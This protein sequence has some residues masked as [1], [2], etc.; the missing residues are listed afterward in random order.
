MNL[1]IASLICWL[2][3]L[4]VVPLQA[5]VIAEWTFNAGTT[6]A[7][8]LASSNVSSG[9]SVTG[10]AFN[11]SFTDFGP[12]AVPNDVHDGFGFGGATEGGAS[13]QVIFLHRANYFDGSSVPSPRPTS[14]DYTSWG[15][16]S[17]AGT[18]ADPSSNGNAPISFT[19]TADALS[20]ITV[21]SL[22]VDFFDQAAMIFFFQEA[23]ATAGSPVTVNTALTSIDV[24]LDDP[25]VI[26]P[27]QTRSFTINLN[28][29][30]LDSRHNLDGLALNGKVQTVIVDDSFAKGNGS[31]EFDAAGAELAADNAT[32]GKWTTGTGVGTFPIDQLLSRNNTPVSDGSHALAI[33]ANGGNT[34]IQGGL[35]N[36]GY[37]VQ[38]DDRFTLSFD[39]GTFAGWVAGD[40][41][42]VH[43]FTTSDD[44]LSGSKTVIYSG[45]VTGDPGANYISESFVSIGTVAPASEGRQLWLEFNTDDVGQFARVDQVM[46]QTA[47]APPFFTDWSDGT[48]IVMP[49]SGEFEVL[50]DW[51]AWDGLPERR[52]LGPDHWANRMQDWSVRD[53][54]LVCDNSKF[55]QTKTVHQLGNQLGIGTEDFSL[56]TRLSFTNAGTAGFG[57]F[58]I[59]GGQGHLNYKGAS[60]ICGTPGKGAG[61]IAAVDYNGGN[62]LSFRDMNDFAPIVHPV[63]LSGAETRFTMTPLATAA[64]L[65]LL[66]EGIHVA[67]SSD[68]TLRLSAWS[69]D[70]STLLGAVELTGVDPHL[71]IGNIALASQGGASSGDVT[72]QRWY[73]RGSKW[74]V[75]SGR[76]FGPVAGTLYSTAA[77]K[78]KV[79]VQAIP[80]SV[81]GSGVPANVTLRI[82][83]QQPDT[84]WLAL[85][86]DEA[87]TS[88]S[89]HHLFEFPGWDTTQG[90]EMRAVLSDADG[91]TYLYPFTVKAEPAPGDTVDAAT[92][93]CT[94]TMGRNANTPNAV[95]QAGEV[96]IPKWLP[97]N[98][99]FPFDFQV[100]QAG[101]KDI[102]I[103]FFTGD[104]IYETRPTQTDFS[105]TP[106]EDYLYKFLLW[107]WAFQPLTSQYPSILQTDDHDVYQPDLFGQDRLGNTEGP[108]N[109]GFQRSFDFLE[110]FVQRTM[111]AHNPDTLEPTPSARTGLSNY[112]TAFDYGDVSFFILEDR[113]F[114]RGTNTT[115]TD[116]PETF[117][118]EIQLEHL[119]DWACTPMPG[120]RKCVVAQTI[121]SSMSLTGA[122]TFNYDIDPNAIYTD[123]RNDIIRM[124]GA[125]GAVI[126]S[127]DQHLC[128]FSRLGWT[129][130]SNTGQAIPDGHYHNGPYQF[131][132][133]PGGNV[134]WRWFIPGNG[135]RQLAPAD[136]SA[137]GHVGGFRDFFGNPFT[138]LAVANPGDEAFSTIPTRI[139]YVL[140]DAEVAAG[141]ELEQ[142]GQGDG[143]GILRFN[144]T[145][146]QLTAEAW[147]VSEDAQYDGFPQVVSYATLDDTTA[148]PV[149]LVAQNPDADGDGI[150]DSVEG[151]GDLDG[152]GIPNFLDPD[153][154]GD[155]VSDADESI[156]GFDPYSSAD[157]SSDQDGDG[158][159]DILEAVAGTSATDRLDLPFL[160][161][162]E[163]AGPSGNRLQFEAKRGRKY[164]VQRS[165]N[166]LT[167]PDPV[168]IDHKAAD[169]SLDYD[170]DTPGFDGPRVFYRLGYEYAGY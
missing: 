160:S 91:Q 133:P 53:G 9:A 113:K 149:P 47:V 39:W 33:G 43:L 71:L 170:D 123:E 18:G 102:D 97:A 107:H 32:P 111:T 106:A 84:T 162:I 51:S 30:A 28:S 126:L 61:I 88:E 169:Q 36:T 100:S 46:L 141:A 70:E 27:G 44:T 152:D 121:Y 8:R 11:G 22:T 117:L 135:V 34:T 24:P 13:E 35:L 23:G 76:G 82:E 57:G 159:T 94:G 147:K 14:A 153:S 119:R 89:Y 116:Y 59:G 115:E 155:G 75:A 73:K 81:Y 50:G 129:Y 65:V 54:A 4:A 25:V 1:R 58:L 16:A 56:K 158:V 124:L 103:L 137:P 42:E 86:A 101:S 41:L 157:A 96:P 66:L 29:G 150:A 17:S 40:T 148:A 161:L 166:L 5:D 110:N 138:M 90:H 12:G 146:Q 165:D 105:A 98:C 52:W 128:T 78:L 99:W 131:C 79:G 108:A 130:D 31:F 80:L 67:P 60:L 77:G 26:G 140:T 10:L 48:P 74:S 109:G 114:K 144:G 104:Q 163:I 134:F 93:S 20:S 69:A 154:D 64:D 72:F 19:V 120:K 125:N 168:V 127:G 55:V 83:K 167:W 118:G 136:G 122:G 68:Y 164:T 6:S 156:F 139:R 151:S 7:A 45:A 85:T 132:A 37:I 38:A 49:D 112:Y 143:F 145:A 87:I 2:A 3:A 15:P 142:I 62:T 63:A 95:P 21:D 92:F